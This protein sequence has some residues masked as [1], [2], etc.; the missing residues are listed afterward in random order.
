M[1]D[2]KGVDKGQDTGPEDEDVKDPI[3]PKDEK[4]GPEPSDSTGDDGEGKDGD[5]EGDGG[6]D[7]GEDSP[8]EG[9]GKPSEL[10]ALKALLAEANK[11]LK[12]REE[13][14]KPD[15]TPAAPPQMTDEQWAK[16]QEEWGMDRRGI[17][18]VTAQN[19][20]LYRKIIGEVSKMMAPFHKER[21]IAQM[22]KQEEF[23]D[24]RQHLSG[25]DEFLANFDDDQHANEKL[26]ALGLM[27]ARGKGLNKAVRTAANSKERNKKIAGAARP[28][29]PS[30]GAAKK[31]S[32]GLNEMERQAARLGGMTDEEYLKMKT[33]RAA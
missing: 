10:D 21:V 11:K 4:D 9:E 30:A 19:A 15:A 20:Y 5:V 12:A 2:G 6:E 33:G 27:Y 22:E 26:L 14:E 32:R 28:A 18:K 3:D 8:E 23:K 13:E 1:L 29:A 31:P 16:V 7:T 24:I 17:E 25:V